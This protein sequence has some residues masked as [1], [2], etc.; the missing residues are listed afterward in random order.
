VGCDLSR[1]LGP[2][3]RLVAPIKEAIRSDLPYDRILYA[4][5]CGFYFR[6]KDETGSY[7]PADLKFYDNFK[8]DIEYL[9]TKVCN[10]NHEKNKELF[11]KARNYCIKINQQYRPEVTIL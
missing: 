9:L 8:P 2:D 7:H 6:A 1:K 5:V 10:L 3:D 11:R 4:L